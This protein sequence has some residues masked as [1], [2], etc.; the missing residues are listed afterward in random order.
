[1]LYYINHTSEKLR[2]FSCKLLSNKLRRQNSAALLSI[3][4]FIHSQKQKPEKN[5]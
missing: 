4:Q 2:L 1:M 3:Y 5:G